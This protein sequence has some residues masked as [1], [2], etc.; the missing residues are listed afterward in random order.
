MLCGEFEPP[1][2]HTMK[3]LILSLTAVASLTMANVEAETSSAFILGEAA[4]VAVDKESGK[5]LH[6]IIDDGDKDGLVG[7]YEAGKIKLIPAAKKFYV[8][9]IGFDFIDTVRY[10]GITYYMPNREL[11]KLGGVQ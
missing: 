8:V 5:S 1:T 7:L 2:Q 3:K 10:Q 4:I 9:S 11:I 6:D